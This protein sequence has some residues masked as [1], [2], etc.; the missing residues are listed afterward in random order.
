MSAMHTQPKE[1]DQRNSKTILVVED[2]A[3]IGELLT[4]AISQETPF[5]A[6]LVLDGFEALQLVHEYTP[7]LFILDYHLPDIN[8]IALYDRLHALKEL[9][10]TPALLISANVPHR[11]IAKRSLTGM[12]KSFDLNQLLA[13]IERLV[14]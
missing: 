14:E 8:G 10:S 5:K 9:A 3:S 12:R 7:S 13:T 1:G 4:L 2:D 6:L 11:E